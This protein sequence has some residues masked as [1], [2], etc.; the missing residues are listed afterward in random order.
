MRKI[1]A[2]TP[3]DEG[4]VAFARARAFTLE[5]TDTASAV[6]PRAVGDPPAPGPG[7]AI[8]PM[9]G[10]A[11]DPTSIFEADRISALDEPGASDYSGMT[12]PDWRR[13]IWDMPDCDHDV[14]VVVLA[15]G[16]VVG[17]S[18]LYTDYVT[19]RARNAGTGVVPD[20][21]GRGLGLLMKRHALALA[22]ARGITRVIT[23]N[24]DTNAP[25]LAI[26]AKL[27]YEPLSKG[28]RGCSSG[29]RRAAPAPPALYMSEPPRLS[30]S[31]RLTPL[32]GEMRPREPSS[33]ERLSAWSA[34]RRQHKR[35]RVTKSLG[36]VPD[37]TAR[38]VVWLIVYD[39]LASLL[40]FRGMKPALAFYVTAF[41]AATFAGLAF[42]GGNLRVTAS[43]GKG[44]SRG[45]PEADGVRNL[46]AL[47]GVSWVVLA[48]GLFGVGL[49]ADRSGASGKDPHA[50]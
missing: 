30:R 13:L 20:F 38:V 31:G 4:S 23:Q 25:M 5:A 2:N 28:T 11:E 1:V 17:T 21:R 22:A 14:S 8:A 16:V 6:D 46:Q 3:S 12:Y 41:P 37:V 43:R 34:H 42:A 35:L 47:A 33:W 9:A 45:T 26:N 15:D 7:L 36:A 50:S 32:S 40:V 39:A 10:F 49:Y 27:G 24:D 48:I 29:D 19:G 44:G 18:F